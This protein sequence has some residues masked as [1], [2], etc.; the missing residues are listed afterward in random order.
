MQ[1]KNIVASFNHAGGIQIGADVRIAGI[2]VGNIDTISLD[3]ETFQ[4]RVAMRIDNDVQLPQN[5]L[6]EIAID[7]FIGKKY[8]RISLPTEKSPINTS[9]VFT[10]TKDTETLE[11]LIGKAIY[12]I[13]N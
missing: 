7:G 9:T 13:Q 11:Q 12:L 10:N 4:A 1:Y 5:A 8:I 3:T 6:F 2:K